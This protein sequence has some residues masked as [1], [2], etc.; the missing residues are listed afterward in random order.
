MTGTCKGVVAN[1]AFRKWLWH[2]AGVTRNLKTNPPLYYFLQSGSRYSPYKRPS[3]KHLSHEIPTGKWHQSF[4]KA[5]LKNQI[6]AALPDWLVLRRRDPGSNSEGPSPGP[7]V[8]KTLILRVSF[9][10]RIKTAPKW[11]TIAVLKYNCSF[12]YVAWSLPAEITGQ[13]VASSGISPYMKESWWL[14]QINHIPS[15]V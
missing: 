7:C 2:L 1:K 13:D 6:Q 14:K 9:L 8:F 4:P 11:R 10:W 3:W 15:A 5:I 12:L